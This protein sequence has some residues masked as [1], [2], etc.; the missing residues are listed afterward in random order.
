MGLLTKIF[1]KMRVP[2]GSGQGYFTTFD[3]YTPVFTS[4]GGEVYENELVRAAIHVRATHVSKLSVQIQG[5]AKPKLQTRLRTGPNEWQ[6]WSQ[7]MYRLSTILDIQNTAFITPVLDEF[8]ET[9]GI[10]PL[11]PSM[12]EIVQYAGA[13]WLRYRFRNGETAAIEMQRCGIMTKFQYHS[14]FFGESNAAL[15]QTM[16]LI[17]VQNQGIGEAVKNSATFR[18]M[19]PRQQF[20]KRYRFGQGETAVFERESEGRR[21]GIAFPEHLY[22]YSANQVYP[23]CG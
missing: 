15:R 14:D 16:E 2:Q 7:F 13:P 11:V 4:W 18:F 17:D 10:Y 5:S 12:C 23:V 20:C 21:R 3:G 6:T 1:G 19:G 8:G 22:G 9:V